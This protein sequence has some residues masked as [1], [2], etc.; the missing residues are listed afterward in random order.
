M[1]HFENFIN[2]FF[3]Y[4]KITLIN[5]FQNNVDMIQIAFNQ[6]SYFY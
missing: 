1:K 2:I 5:F 4:L 3:E 6:K